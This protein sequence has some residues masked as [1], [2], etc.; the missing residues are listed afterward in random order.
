MPQDD[1]PEVLAAVPDGKPY[2]KAN[3]ANVKSFSTNHVARFRLCLSF[4]LPFFYK[5][6]VQFIL[7][8][9]LGGFL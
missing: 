2:G 7:L 1:S 4:G 9:T 3:H 8:F 6:P 5:Q